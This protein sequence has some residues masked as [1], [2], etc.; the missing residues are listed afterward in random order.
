MESGNENK[1][2]ITKNNVECNGE[3]DCATIE[4]KN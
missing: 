4:I 3:D 2:K 1:D